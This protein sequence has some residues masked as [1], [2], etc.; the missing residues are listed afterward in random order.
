MTWLGS[1]QILFLIFCLWPLSTLAEA[2]EA[3]SGQKQQEKSQ[4]PEGSLWRV[5]EFGKTTRYAGI[6]RLAFSPNGKLLAARNQEMEVSIIDVETQKTISEFEGHEQTIQTIDFSPNSRY[7]VTAAG[8]S[9]QVKVWDVQT[10]KLDA[11]ID[12]DARAAYFDRTGDRILVL[13]ASEL[14]VYSFPGSQ[15]IRSRK[16][17]SSNE[18]ALFM[19]RDGRLIVMYRMTNNVGQTMVMDTETRSR[20]IL[21]GPAL[22][23]RGIA[24]SN[25]RNWLALSYSRDTRVHVWD[26]RAPHSR[27]YQLEGH[28]APIQTLSFSNDSRYLLSDGWDDTGI[29][30]E[31]ASRQLVHISQGHTENVNASAFSPTG[32]RYATGASGKTDNS[33]IYWKFDRHVLVPVNRPVDSVDEVWQGLASSDYKAAMVE[34]NRIASEPDTWLPGLKSRIEAVTQLQTS[35]TIETLVAMLNSP[36]FKARENALMQLIALRVQSDSQIRAALENAKSPEVKYRL[37]KV[38]RMKISRPEHDD[39]LE[40]Q[41]ARLIMALELANTDDSRQL[42]QRIATGHENVD[43]ARAASGALNRL[44]S[45]V[46]LKK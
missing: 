1:V 32:F 11:K 41:W 39:K 7:L 27:S 4:L 44:K 31:V 45:R 14:E 35:G 6:Y 28:G 19:S 29:L 20:V 26:L 9:E 46:S 2:Q 24:F 38:L 17:K 13:G 25:D 33:T 5:G 22:R 34:V 43:F 37:R 23:P 16:W 30:W 40:R 42:L 12:T 3:K 8:E 36:N 21:P 18:S 15:L 10:G